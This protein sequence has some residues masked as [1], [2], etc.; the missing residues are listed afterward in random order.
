MQQ[1]LNHQ[2]HPWGYGIITSRSAAVTRF[3]S[4]V[5][6][7]GRLQLPVSGVLRVEAVSYPVRGGGAWGEST[8]GPFPSPGFK[9][10]NVPSHPALGQ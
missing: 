4:S 8:P 6:E 3:M 2:P 7:S 10:I 9:R 5:P 1:H